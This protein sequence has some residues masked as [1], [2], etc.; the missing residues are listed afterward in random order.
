LVRVNP[1]VLDFLRGL[2][3]DF[4]GADAP[5]EPT[6]PNVAQMLADGVAPDEIGRIVA[7]NYNAARNYSAALAAHNARNA[8]AVNAADA[9]R[10][11]RPVSR[12]AT[13]K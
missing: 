11:A 3:A 9:L 12:K 6:A 5:D 1:A 4:I 8:T 13:E 7:E 10:N 2:V